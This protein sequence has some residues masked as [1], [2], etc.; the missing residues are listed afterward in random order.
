MVI[1]TKISNSILYHFNEQNKWK[2]NNYDKHWPSAMKEQ[3][4][5]KPFVY[6]LHVVIIRVKFDSA[7]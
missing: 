2:N 5:C 4:H 6:Y 1:L 7:C 3:S